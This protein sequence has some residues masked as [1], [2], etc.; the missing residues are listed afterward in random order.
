MGTFHNSDP[1]NFLALA[2]LQTGIVAGLFGHQAWLRSGGWLFAVAG[3]YYCARF[4][5]AGEAA[6]APGV[7]VVLGVTAWLLVLSDRYEVRR[8]TRAARAFASGEPGPPDCRDADDG[9][10]PDGPAWREH[11]TH[12]P[13]ADEESPRLRMPR[14]DTREDDTE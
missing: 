6:M 13:G 4:A 11:L 9:E 7:F 14:P 1:I 5:A 8:L 12:T 10:V 3:G 2:A